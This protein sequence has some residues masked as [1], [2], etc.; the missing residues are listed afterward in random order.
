MLTASC[1]VLLFLQPT[2]VSHQA[3]E[4]RQLHARLQA[5]IENYTLTA[6][7]L[8]RAM[9]IR[10]EK[11][12]VQNEHI[13]V[14][15]RLRLYP[16]VHHVVSPPVAATSSG[17]EGGTG[18][19]ISSGLGDERVSFKLRNVMV[20]E[21]LDEFSLAAG[22]KIWIVTYPEKATLTGAGFRRTVSLYSVAPLPDEYQP[23]WE[24]LPWSVEPPRK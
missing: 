18:Y 7:S 21:I 9:N 20:R 1:L 24:F 13:A 6:D 2:R 19:H 16:L 10:I 4:S 23:L 14:A 3:A 11:F 22:L 15:S 5:K 12:E 8:L 17:S